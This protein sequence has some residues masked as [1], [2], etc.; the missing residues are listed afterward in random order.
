LLKDWVPPY[1]DPAVDFR[2]VAMT[3]A[4]GDA[5]FDAGTGVHRRTA[6][7]ALCTSMAV[8]ESFS[9]PK[10]PEGIACR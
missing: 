10:P 4:R 6:L 7:L 8:G 9:A 1:D 2:I 3:K 5:D